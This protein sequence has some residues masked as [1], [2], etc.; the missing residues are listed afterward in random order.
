MVFPE[1]QTLLR[2][3]PDVDEL[4]SKEVIAVPHPEDDPVVQNDPR[5]QTEASG[6]TIPLFVALAIGFLLFSQ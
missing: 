4:V 1:K 3:A 2:A 6:A 5:N